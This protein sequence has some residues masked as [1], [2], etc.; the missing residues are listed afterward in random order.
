MPIYDYECEC[1]WKGEVITSMDVDPPCP[2]CDGDMKRLM[3]G[4][5]GIAMG[6]GP[7]G[8]Y[9]D[10]LQSYV[11]TNAEK[12]RLMQEQGITEKY[13]KGWV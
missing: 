10:N 8:Y 11:S 5:H 13:G 1:G 9:D 6:V 3:P 12:R 2:E 4:T 7:Y